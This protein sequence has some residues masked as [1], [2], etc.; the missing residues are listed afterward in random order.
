MNGNFRNFAIWIVIL[1]LLLGLFQVFN[2]STQTASVGK[3]TY[4][5]LSL[6]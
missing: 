1:V 6:K 4:L 2:T 3:R 5:N